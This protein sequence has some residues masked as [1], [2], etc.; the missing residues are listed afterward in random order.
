MVL[1]IVES[2]GMGV[3]GSAGDWISVDSTIYVYASNG[4]CTAEDTFEIT[5]IPAA[6]VDILPDLSSCDSLELPTLTNGDYFTSTMGGGTALNAGDYITSDQDIYVYTDNGSCTAEDTFA[7]TILVG[8]AVDII[9]DTT[10]CDSLALPILTDGTYYSESN[11]MGMMGSAGD[12]ISG[13]STIYVYAD[14]GSCTAEDT[15]EI[16]IIPAAVVDILPDMSSCDSLELPT[17]NE[18]GL[19]YLY[20]GRRYCIKCRRLHYLRPRHLYLYR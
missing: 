20:D 10:A 5:I 14:N 6:V 3:M 15:F 1:T 2:N 7:V 8:V 12:W 11:G 19:L 13:D 17:A 16:T 18:W 4:T 9:A